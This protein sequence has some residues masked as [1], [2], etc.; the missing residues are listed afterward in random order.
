MKLYSAIIDLAFLK[1]HYKNKPVQT[2]FVYSNAEADWASI[3]KFI[4]EKAFVYLINDKVTKEDIGYENPI[5]FKLLNDYWEGKSKNLEIIKSTQSLCKYKSL[6][7][8]STFFLIDDHLIGFSPSEYGLVRYKSDKILSKWIDR[9]GLTREFLITGKDLK[10]N[11]LSRWCDFKEFSFSGTQIII[12]D[13]YIFSNSN[14]IKNN[15]AKLIEA[16]FPENLKGYPYQ[17]LVVS[18]SFYKIENLEREATI[19]EVYNE[20][21]K[22]LIIVLPNKTFNLSIVKKQV[23]EYHDRHIITDY[24]RIKSSNSI[25]FFDKNGNTISPSTVTFEPVAHIADNGDTTYGTNTIQFLKEIKEI[26]AGG[27]K[28]LIR[29]NAELKILEFIN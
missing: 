19:D 8:L 22:A 27:N 29:G 20:V 13:N 3:N 16:F 12:A 6:K 2:Q 26:V 17:I 21:S 25:S 4:L 1:N 7:S 5:A 9:K 18:K 15:F 10:Q 11:R 14:N 28:R 23:K 24:I